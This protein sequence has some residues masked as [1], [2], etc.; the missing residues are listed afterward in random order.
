MENQDMTKADFRK[1]LYD[2]YITSFKRYISKKNSKSI[3]SDYK[4]FKKRY[5]PLLKKVSPDSSII[6]FGCGPGYMLNFLKEE[7]FSNLYGID[8][9]EQQIDVAK[10]MGLNVEVKNVF[11]Y[12]RT[13]K[14]TFDAAFALD[15]VEHFDKSEIFD[16]FRGIYETLNDNGFLIIHTPNGQGIL[17]GRNIYGDLTHLTIFNPNSLTQILKL[18]GFREIKFY[19]TGPVSKNLTGFIRLILWNTIKV[20]IKIVKAAETG[21]FDSILTENFICSAQK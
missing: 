15:F 21:R 9:S 20:V 5:I 10:Q 19:E 6:E 11:E 17:P 13:N 12:F 4:V 8:V 18:T 1:N 14:R 2:N 3:I 16:L 7:G